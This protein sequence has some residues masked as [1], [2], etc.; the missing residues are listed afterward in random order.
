VGY[1]DL[2]WHFDKAITYHY[3]VSDGGLE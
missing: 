2:K 3:F 1:V